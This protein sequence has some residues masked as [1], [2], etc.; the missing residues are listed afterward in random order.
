MAARSEPYLDPDVLAEGRHLSKDANLF[1]GDA[2][3]NFNSPSEDLLR[4]QI[5]QK[6][7]LA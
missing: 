3:A 1:Q 7:V 5:T 4:Q 6:S 2:E